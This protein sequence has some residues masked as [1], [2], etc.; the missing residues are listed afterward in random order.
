MCHTSVL[1]QTT[2]THPI[3]KHIIVNGAKLW[4][5]TEGK[6]DP[7]FLI[8]GGPGDSHMYMHSFD[9][10][11]DSF[12]LV[13]IDNFGRGKSDTAT[14]ISKYSIARDVEDVEGIRKSLGFDKINL[15][16]HSYGSIA[17]QLYAI[18]YG[19]NLKH[20]IIAD[21]FYSNTMWQENDDNS[22]REY[23]END[24]EL[25]D[26]LM[27]LRSQGYRSSDAKH[28]DLYFR[29]HSPLLYYY[30]PDNTKLE[31]KDNSY[32][33]DFNK[34]LYYH[35]VGEDGDFVVGNE[36]AKFDVRNELKNL[37]MPVLIIAGRYDRVSVP[38]FA[39]LYKKYCPQAKFVMFEHSGHNPQI[40]E[41][42]K[43]FDLIR[44][45]LR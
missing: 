10:L 6:G 9:G 24:P 2:F 16:G 43:E 15:L 4:I 28:L 44:T 14:D 36:I 39:I 11:K 21:G 18:K 29:F 20:L 13:F 42:E 12:L 37:K 45:F 32:P 31:Q 8:A 26:S 1:A 5:E 33:N 35:Y 7:L 40:E 30:C 22:N 19:I 34:K 41:Q 3:G 38:K 27:V 23:A 25:W 17:V